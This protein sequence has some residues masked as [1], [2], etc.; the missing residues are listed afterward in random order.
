M[1]PLG[2]LYIN[3]KKLLKTAILLVQELIKQEKQL[4]FGPTLTLILPI[5]GQCKKVKLHI[6]KKFGLSTF[7]EILTKYVYNSTVI[8]FNVL[9]LCL[10][11]YSEAFNYKKLSFTVTKR[12]LFTYKIR[13][14]LSFFLLHFQVLYL[15]IFPQTSTIFLKL[16]TCCLFK[17][18]KSRIERC[19]KA[20]SI[21]KHVFY[22]M[23]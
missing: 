6:L 11:G 5:F 15:I 7:K 12:N 2:W 20:K 16:C 18:D 22:K 13:F 21:F 17:Y 4:V 19:S 3:E 1:L 14:A 10:K 8:F 23:Y 9:L